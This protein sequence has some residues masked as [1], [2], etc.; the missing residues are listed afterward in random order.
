[1]QVYFHIV[2]LNATSQVPLV[3]AF[4]DSNLFAQRCSCFLT[5]EDFNYVIK[6]AVLLIFNSALLWPAH[7]NANTTVFMLN[8][9]VW[10]QEASESSLGRVI[11]IEFCN[12]L[13]HPILHLN[14]ICSD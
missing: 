13:S 11:N 7:K 3:E 5:S 14:R 1:M 8:V 2:D 10:Q 9:M 6:M 4:D 12:P